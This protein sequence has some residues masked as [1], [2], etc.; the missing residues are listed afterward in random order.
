MS[1]QQTVGPPQPG[2]VTY[3]PA[4]IQAEYEEM[5]RRAGGSFWKMVNAED[6]DYRLMPA[7]ALKFPEAVN[8]LFY[9]EVSYHYKVGTGPKP[10]TVLCWKSLGMT[11]CPVCDLVD[12]LFDSDDKQLL[13]VAKE[14]VAKRKLF[15]NLIDMNAAAKGVQ[16]GTLPTSVIKQILAFMGESGMYG[17]VTDIYTGRNIRTTRAAE[18]SF[19]MYSSQAWPNAEAL[20]DEAQIA[21][22]WEQM[23][24][25][26]TVINKP[27]TAEEMAQ[28]VSEAS[29]AYFNPVGVGPS[30][31]L[32]ASPPAAAPLVA[33]PAPAPLAVAMGDPVMVAPGHAAPVAPAPAPVAPAPAP[34][35]TQVAPPVAPATPPAPAGA[36]PAPL[37]A[38]PSAVAI[39][40]A[41]ASRLVL[42]DVDATIH[43]CFGRSYDQSMTNCT[44][45][46]KSAECQGVIAGTM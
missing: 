8:R 42:Y 13:A 16:I 26:E 12:R 19:D 44:L 28:I 37:Q 43:H 2:Q 21:S 3:D 4:Q 29:A 1:N 25:L 10:P 34:F 38:A 18:T 14:I 27:K 6:Y 36:P 7:Y 40:D 46:P 20:G 35:P 15:V 32:P 24:N 23:G 22:L 11:T 5:C 30:P 31:T 33:A 17:D 41:I 9:Y 45:C 39:P